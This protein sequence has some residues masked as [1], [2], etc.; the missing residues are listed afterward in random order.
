M[1]SSPAM[2]YWVE[3]LQSQGRYTFTRSEAEAGT[4][5]S[6]VA[7]QSAL[8]RLAAQRRIVCPRRGFYV[9]VPAEYRAAGSVPA[10]WFVDDFM[11]HLDQP[12]Y[13]GLLSAAAYHGAGH[14]QPMVFQVVTNKP[15]RKVRA[16]RVVL[17]FWMSSRVTQMPV[18]EAR[19][20][21]GTMRIATPEATAFDLVRYQAGAG[22]LSNAA[23]VLVELAER[24]DA[25]A[26]V[27][28]APLV[29]IPDVQRLGYLLDAVGVSALADPLA[30]WL[31][32]RP[33]RAVRLRPGGQ[34]NVELEQRWH[35]L[36]NEELDIDL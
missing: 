36:P 12:Y 17:Q 32:T 16:G 26:L 29:R 9:V 4:K 6:F 28:M 1:P 11:G 10:S 30:R 21:T 15:T 5:R 19:T 31:Q 18:T 14:Q 34:A 25:E 24:I 2:S 35:V 33:R 23:T 8:R 3:Q 22:H 27:G 20:E 13:V 7:T